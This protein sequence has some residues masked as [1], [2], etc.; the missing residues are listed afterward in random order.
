MDIKTVDVATLDTTQKIFD[1]AYFFLLDQ[2]GQ[3]MRKSK[4]SGASV[5]AYR[6]N[7]G[8]KCGAGCL[9]TDEEYNK[10]MEGLGWHGYSIDK[11]IPNRLTPFGRIISRIQKI[12]DYWAQSANASDWSNHIKKEFGIAAKDFSLDMPS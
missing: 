5:C 7:E 6:G 2:G 3:S 8:R 10:N 12:H 4:N 1:Y 11:Y 9:L